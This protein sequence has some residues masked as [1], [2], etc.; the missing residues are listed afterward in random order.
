MDWVVHP[1]AGMG[2]AFF[3]SVLFT[4][5]GR[6]WPAVALASGALL[7]LAVLG[8]GWV[9][10]PAAGML[11]GYFGSS[12]FGHWQRRWAALL[13]ALIASL[14]FMAGGASWMIFPL[15]VM[16]FVWL[17]TAAFSFMRPAA[18]GRPPADAPHPPAALP[19]Q[20]GGLPFGGWSRQREKEPVAASRNDVSPAKPAAVPADAADS[21]TA[22]LRDDRLP[23]EA[24]AQLVAL[25][26]RTRE[27]LAQLRELGQEGGEA[28]YL[29]RAIRD[30]YVPTAVGAYLRLPRTRA[31]TV[32]LE[33]GK[34]GRDLLLEQLE[35]LLNAVQDILDSAFQ[36]GSR[37][38]LTHQRFLEDRFQQ[39]SARKKSGDLDL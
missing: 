6:Q 30:E 7:L 8:A 23:G 10:H 38:L 20:A 18:T 12:A 15:T 34:T 27:A 37:E 22:W 32:A 9:V 4:R 21:Y 13:T 36:T 39:V 29:A 11:L 1:L 35:L 14:A 24:R 33:G 3:A 16:G 25:N 2:L 5:R 19:Q 28:G 26:L 17:M 31:D